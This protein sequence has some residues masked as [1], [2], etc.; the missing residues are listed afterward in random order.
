M[1]LQEKLNVI[2]ICNLNDVANKLQAQDTAR[3]KIT[4]KVSN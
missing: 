1:K 3:K 2:C 4:I